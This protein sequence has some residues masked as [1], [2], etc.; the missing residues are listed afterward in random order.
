MCG[1]L[2][3]T[4]DTPSKQNEDSQD[5]MSSSNIRGQSIVENK[6]V[7]DVLS[8]RH[9]VRFLGFKRHSNQSQSNYDKISSNHNSPMHHTK[10][11]STH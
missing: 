1:H 9:K 5:K 10:R 3:R 6:D 7:T 4:L 8:N 11:F 2:L